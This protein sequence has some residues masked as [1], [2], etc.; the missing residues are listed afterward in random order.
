MEAGVVDMKAAVV[1]IKVAVGTADGTNA[2]LLNG[3]AVSTRSGG[4][5]LLRRFAFAR[6]FAWAHCIL[7]GALGR[8]AS[9]HVQNVQAPK[10]SSTCS[11][12]QDFAKF[13]SQT[14]SIDRL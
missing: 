8:V 12:E 5:G 7:V 10:H 2:Y 6:A 13:G 1:A 4:A 9:L 11:M 14:G 3:T